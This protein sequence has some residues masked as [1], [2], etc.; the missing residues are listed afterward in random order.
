MGKSETTFN[1]VIFFFT[2][3]F[4]ISSISLAQNSGYEQTESWETSKKGGV[5]FRVYGTHSVDTY[6]EYSEIFN[7]RDKNFN[8]SIGLAS[9][10]VTC[11]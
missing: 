5:C 1:V 2:I 10:G 4:F 7:D 9:E 6:S 11:Q 3:L 8:F